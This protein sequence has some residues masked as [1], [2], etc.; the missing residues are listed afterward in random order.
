MNKSTER[1]RA[2]VMKIG[3]LFN[4]TEGELELI[5]SH[6]KKNLLEILYNFFDQLCDADFEHLSEEDIALL[7]YYGYKTEEEIV[8]ETDFK[9]IPFTAYITYI[10]MRKKQPFSMEE[11][12]LDASYFYKECTGLEMEK[13][14]AEE[15]IKTVFSVLSHRNSAYI[16]QVGDG[17]YEVN[18]LAAIG[19]N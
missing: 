3:I 15:D 5:K 10:M 2:L 17:Q 8:A 9:S 4:L 7:R 11:I 13:E 1:L 19:G 16:L 12:L 18:P 6:N 14:K